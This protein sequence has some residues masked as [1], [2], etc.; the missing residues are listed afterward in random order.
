MSNEADGNGTWVLK[1]SCWVSICRDGCC[2]VFGLIASQWNSRLAPSPGSC[3]TSV[4][5]CC[6]SPGFR[7][8]FGHKELRSSWMAWRMWAW[9]H[10][11]YIKTGLQNLSFQG[12]CISILSL[13]H[14][15]VP[16]AHLAVLV[17]R[18]LPLFGSSSNGWVSNGPCLNKGCDCTGSQSEREEMMKCVCVCVY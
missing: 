3:V 7:S 1:L 18:G 2:L 6:S 13:S 8:A 4:I 5:R 10:T 14:L 16:S 12:N 11:D 15:S 9:I 17:Y